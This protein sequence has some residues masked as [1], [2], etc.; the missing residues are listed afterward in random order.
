[1][2][3]HNDS[4]T[5]ISAEQ[6][7]RSVPRPDAMLLNPPARTRVSDE[8]A[9]PQGCMWRVWVQV[10][11]TGGCG[12]PPGGE[13]AER[14]PSCSEHPDI[15]RRLGARSL[16]TDPRVTD[17]NNGSRCVMCRMLLTSV[18]PRTPVRRATVALLYGTGVLLSTKRVTSACRS[19]RNARRRTPR[20][21][22]SP[23][24]KYL[25]VLHSEREPLDVDSFLS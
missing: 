24:S 15:S 10:Y 11:F 21:L 22:F 17:S 7:G 4:E 19:D 13:R 8:Y 18:T 2:Y 3:N 5:V 20:T 9:Q 6:L 25:L 1:M 12:V 14:A 16:H 23:R